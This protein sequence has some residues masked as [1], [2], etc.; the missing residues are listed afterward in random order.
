MNLKKSIAFLFAAFLGLAPIAHAAEPYEVPV[1][2]YDSAGTTS[3]TKSIIPFGTGAGLMM[4]SDSSGV[5][6]PVYEALFSRIDSTLYFDAINKF[7]GVSSLPSSKIT[8]LDTAL[9]DRPTYSEVSASISAAVANKADWPHAH[10]IGQITNLQS[11][12]DSKPTYGPATTATSGLMTAVDKVRVDTLWA[13]SSTPQSLSFANPSRTLNSAFQISSTRAS[14]ASYSVDVAATATLAGGQTGT[15]FLEYANDS[16]FTSGVTE[17]ARF[18]NGNSVSLAIAITV[19]QNVTG[20]LTGMIPAGKYVRV[21]TAN[22][23]GNP[24]FTYRSG[25]EVLLASN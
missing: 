1:T 22:T 7:F 8:G 10:P 14:F 20:T 9:G 18:V 21:R 25:Q 15:V 6:A 23:V 2:Q 3:S 24:T 19:N 13:A 5:D 16:G 12:L 17:V 11:V 4:F